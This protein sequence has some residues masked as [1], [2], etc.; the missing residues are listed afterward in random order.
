MPRLQ[1]HLEG[2]N[3][4]HLVPQ[5]ITRVGGRRGLG[6][7]LLDHGVGMLYGPA[8]LVEE[9]SQLPREADIPQAPF[10]PPPSL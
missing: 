3:P 5:W 8:K 9:D 1:V 4:L 2:G 6:V 7:P 10:H